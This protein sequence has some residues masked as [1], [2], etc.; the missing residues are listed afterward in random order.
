MDAPRR[1][2]LLL[3]SSLPDD[4]RVRAALDRLA[5]LGAA[6]PLT[7]IRRFPSHSGGGEYYNALARL[8]AALGRAALRE[9]LRALEAA[10]GRRRD[11]PGEVA[12]DVDILAGLDGT[13]WRAD[14]HARAKGEFGRAPVQALLRQAGIGDVDMG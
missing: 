14:P 1:W 8:D 3:G 6:A 2:L 4:A 9:R 12:I 5:E 7:P 10:L 13:R 11:V